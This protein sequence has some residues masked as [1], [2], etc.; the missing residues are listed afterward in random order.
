[1]KSQNINIPDL[2]TEIA[3]EIRASIKNNELDIGSRLPSETEL[4]EHHDNL[5]IIHGPKDDDMKKPR[6]R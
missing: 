2:S 4:A 6:T 3:E 1:M 5:A